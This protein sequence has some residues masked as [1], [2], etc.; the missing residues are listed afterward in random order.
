MSEKKRLLVLGASGVTGQQLLQQA[1][2]RKF[3]VTALVRTPSKITIKHDN[4]SVKVGSVFDKS[5]LQPHVEEADVILS[6]LGFSL[7][8]SHP[9]PHFL[10]VAQNLSDCMKEAGKRRVIFMHSWYTDPASHVHASFIMRNVFLW[11]VIGQ[12]L[13][14]MRQSELFLEGTDHLDFTCVLAAGLT[15]DPVTD[16]TF[17]I[18]DTETI[19]HGVP[20]RIA[21]AD[22]ARYMLDIIDDAGSFRKVRAIAVGAPTSS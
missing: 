17:S 9:V 18:N 5:Q 22:V 16:Q 11:L 8:W 13:A 21:R 14:G 6:C 19:V 4:L 10:T 1:L 12:N 20:H 2:Q 3:H 15:N 7:A